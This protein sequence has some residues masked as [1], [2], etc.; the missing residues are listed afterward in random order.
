MNANAEI[1]NAENANNN[2]ENPL[3]KISGLIFDI[4]DKIPNGVYLELMNNTKKLYDDMQKVKYR[5]FNFDIMTIED[6]ARM[7]KNEDNLYILRRVQRE[8]VDELNSVIRFYE[9]DDLLSP[10]RDGFVGIIIRLFSAGGSYKFM[11]I[12]KINEKSIKYDILFMTAE[13]TTR[14]KK[15]CKLTFRSGE[16]Y[17]NFSEYATKQI[18][19]YETCNM[20]CNYLINQHFLNWEDAE[21][22]NSLKIW[23]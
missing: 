20:V 19:F 8:E 18:L 1:N 14:I 13:H 16:Y 7:I 2:E 17:E 23:N 11:R 6:K 22:D 3:E 15:D 12:T 10:V 9:K 21:T 4:A 5:P